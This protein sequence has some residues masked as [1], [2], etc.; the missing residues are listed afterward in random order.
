MTTC[1]YGQDVRH[2]HHAHLEAEPREHLAPLAVVAVG[3]RLAPAD[4][5]AIERLG[6]EQARTRLGGDVLDEE[7]AAGDEED[8]EALEHAPLVV[9]REVVHHVEDVGGVEG[10]LERR[11]AHVADDE[12]VLAQPRRSATRRAMSMR[13]A[14]GSTPTMR[15]RGCVCP[16]YAAKRPKPQPTSRMRPSSVRS[17]SM[18]LRSF[19]RR[20]EKRT[21]EYARSTSG[22][23]ADDAPD[24]V[25]AVDLGRLRLDDRRRAATRGAHGATRARDAGAREAVPRRGR[26]AR[27][28]R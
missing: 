13:R 25:A 7:H 10:P 22:Q 8:A 17:R 2:A 12:A 9:L 24:G 26:C 11:V 23:R 28:E 21:S 19:G 5:Q 20:I 1:G 4:H 15:R 14:S 16:K 18:T 27:G 3:E 6:E